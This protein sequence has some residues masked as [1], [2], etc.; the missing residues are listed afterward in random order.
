[1]KFSGSFK[2]KVSVGKL[3]VIKLFFGSNLKLREKRVL[4]S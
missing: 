4:Q 2:K 1:M 3:N